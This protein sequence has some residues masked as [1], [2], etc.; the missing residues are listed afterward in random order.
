MVFEDF[1]SCLFV[2]DSESSIVRIVLLK[3]G[4]VKYF[5]GGERDFMNLFVF[6]DVDGVGINVKF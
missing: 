3:D 6:G 2:V 4:V 1:W 5:V